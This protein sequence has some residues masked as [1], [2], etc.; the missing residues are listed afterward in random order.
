MATHNEGKAVY[1]SRPEHDAS[2]LEPVKSKKVG[3]AGDNSRPS[4]INIENVPKAQRAEAKTWH[5]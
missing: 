1:K 2:A 3:D 4:N 5:R